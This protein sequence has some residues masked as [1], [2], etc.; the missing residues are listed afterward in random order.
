MLA[1]VAGSKGTD[2]PKPQTSLETV[3]PWKSLS[4]PSALISAEKF[5]Y[6]SIGD[7]E[8]Y[9]VQKGSGPDFI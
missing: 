5:G 3:Q 2:V 8:I 9:Y 7:T 1:L 6:I 4:T